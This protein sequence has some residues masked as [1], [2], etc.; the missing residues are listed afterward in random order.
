MKKFIFMIFLL[1]LLLFFHEKVFIGTKQGLLL[2]YQT[3]IPS[4]LPFILVTNAL[5]ETNAYQSAAIYFRKYLSDKIYDIMAILIGSLCGYPIGAKI[6]NDFVINKYISPEKGNRLLAFSS[7]TSPMFLIGYIHLHILK[8]S[9]PLS[10]FLLS[11][12]L[13]VII[14]YLFSSN[15]NITNTIC[16][17]DISLKKI[18]ICDTFLHAVQTMVMIGIYVIIFSI[19]ILILSPFC[20]HHFLKILLSFLEITTGLKLLTA[21]PLSSTIRTAFIC[22]LSSFGGLCSVFQIKSVI[23]YPNATIK[24][25]LLSKLLLS[26]GTFLIIIFYLT[27]CLN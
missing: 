19:L 23:H 14:L 21:L 7:Q 22:S 9:V 25:Y 8:A 26:A 4:L 1:F 6:I 17:T 10:V 27:I 2:W 18:C 11:L 24:K 15:D 13:P 16:H 3:L 5:S 12:Y 20:R